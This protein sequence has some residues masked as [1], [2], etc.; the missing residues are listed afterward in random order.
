MINTSNTPKHVSVFRLYCSMNTMTRADLVALAMSANVNID[1]QKSTADLRSEII[2]FAKEHG[3][4]TIVQQAATVYRTPTEISFA[5]GAMSRDAL[6]DDA[7]DYGLDFNKHTPSDDLRAMLI[8][9]M[10]DGG[11]AVANGNPISNVQSERSPGAE[12]STPTVS[13]LVALLKEVQSDIKVAFGSYLPGHE[14][15]TEDMDWNDLACTYKKICKALEGLPP[16]LAN[17]EVLAQVVVAA[18][19]EPEFFPGATRQEILH[20]NVVELLDPYDDPK[21][22]PECDWIE[23]EASFVSSDDSWE[24]V[25]NLAIEPGTPV[26]EKLAPAI[27]A[28]RDANM[29]Y[30]IFFQG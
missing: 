19:A 12:V 24:F 26:P 18:Q 16:E 25:L 17:P 2:N 28:A 13:D 8:E 29:A 7:A 5:V 6:E 27:K 1:V 14:I 30:I 23:N 9:A 10:T 22:V 3:G 20:I 11:L 15:D 4:L 21:G